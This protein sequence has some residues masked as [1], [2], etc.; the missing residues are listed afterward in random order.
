M[1]TKRSD[2]PQRPAGGPLESLFDPRL[3]RALADPT[4]LALVMRLARSGGPATVGQ[5]AEGLPVDLSVVS[6]HLAQ[7]RDAGVLTSA[8]EGKQVSYQLCCES[9]AQTLRTIAAGLENCCP[10]APAEVRPRGRRG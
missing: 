4:R 6:R 9:L 10:S 5:L 3:F 1:T 8:R 2:R 7:L